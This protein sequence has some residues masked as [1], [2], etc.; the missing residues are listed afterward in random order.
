MAKYT[1]IVMLLLLSGSTWAQLQPQRAFLTVHELLTTVQVNGSVTASQS[2]LRALAL[3]EKP[4]PLLMVDG[5]KHQWPLLTSRWVIDT[6]EI[7]SVQVVTGLSAK[8]Y[9]PEAAHGVVHIRTKP[10]SLW[11]KLN[12]QKK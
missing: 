6:E 4:K 12:A 8:A 9:G 2:G 1:A 10:D 11:R 5:V 3:I 7:E